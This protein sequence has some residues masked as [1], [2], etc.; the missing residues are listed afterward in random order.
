MDV[1]DHKCEGDEL[2]D[3]AHRR[4]QSNKRHSDCDSR[5]ATPAGNRELNRYHDYGYILHVI[6]YDTLRGN[7]RRQ[8]VLTMALALDVK[9]FS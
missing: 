7:S 4:L 3:N 2:N 9:K 5:V 1:G 6:W 8:F